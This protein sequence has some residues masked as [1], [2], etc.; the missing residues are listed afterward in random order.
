MQ[1]RTRVVMGSLAGAV[2]VHLAM[3]AC[4]GS[5]S[6]PGA[7]GGPDDAARDA[8]GDLGPDVEERDV[9]ADRGGLDVAS[10]APKDRGVVDAMLDAVRD[11]LSDILD[12]EVRDAAAG[13]DGGVSPRVCDCVPPAPEHT[14]S[15]ALTA[16]DGTTAVRPVPGYTSV[17]SAVTRR[18]LNNDYPMGVYRIE[19]TATFFTNQAVGPAGSISEVTLRCVT[20]I[21]LGSLTLIPGDRPRCSL[22]GTIAAGATTTNY[23]G[24]LREGTDAEVTTLTDTQLRYRIPRVIID[25]GGGPTSVTFTNLVFT[26]SVPGAHFTALADGFRPPP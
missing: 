2:A 24:T 21:R 13:G 14:V 3:I 16:P 15:F 4:T 25:G 19:S 10:D 6:T 1:I 23:S 26:A 5:G 17:T 7:D 20:I 9:A 11:T 12:A 8:Q 22:S 18:P